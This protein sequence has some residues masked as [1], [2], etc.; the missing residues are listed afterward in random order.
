MVNKDDEIQNLSININEVG[1]I[2][3]AYLPGIG[4]VLAKRIIQ[5]RIE[6]DGFKTQ[7][8]LLKVSGI[9]PKVLSKIKPHIILE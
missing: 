1:E 2:E 8:D 9:G 4:P 3:M 6:L 7:D 5:K